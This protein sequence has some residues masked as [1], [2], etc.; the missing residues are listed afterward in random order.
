MSGSHREETMFSA[1]SCTNKC[2]HAGADRCGSY[3]VSAAS[4]CTVDLLALCGRILSFLQ[5]LAAV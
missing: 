2:T 1:I 5:L 4:D 3:V